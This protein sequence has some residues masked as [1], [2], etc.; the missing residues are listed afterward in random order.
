VAGMSTKSTY[1][2]TSTLTTT[3]IEARLLAADTRVRAAAND[4]VDRHH[5]RAKTGPNWLAD[6]P[7]AEC[8]Y[9]PPVPQAVLDVV[10]GDGVGTWSRGPSREQ[11]FTAIHRDGLMSRHTYHGSPQ[12]LIR[13]NA[14]PSQ[15]VAAIHAADEYA[16]EFERLATEYRDTITR[17]NAAHAASQA[18]SV[19]EL[20]GLCA[21]QG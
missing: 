2:S 20:V 6:A 16:A 21:D 10:A 11:Q 8:P 1:E 13:S 5:K 7:F 9:V 15:L 3:M 12:P 18:D 17:A 19:R 14:T 4:M